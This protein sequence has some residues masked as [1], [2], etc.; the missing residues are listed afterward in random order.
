MPPEVKLAEEQ[1][2]E[3]WSSGA[4]VYAPAEYNHYKILFRNAKEDL[5]KEKSRFVW[6]QDYQIAQSEFRDV[7]KVGY[8]LQEKILKQKNIKKESISN[9]I[10]S[11]KNRIETL[12]GLTEKI[13]EGRLARKDLV[14]AELLLSEATV[15]YNKMIMWLPR[16]K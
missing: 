8:V 15:R 14:K 4:E 3:L 10:S 16:T 6:F 13:N 2:H 11:F 7:L 9:Q 1:E 5:I 12:K